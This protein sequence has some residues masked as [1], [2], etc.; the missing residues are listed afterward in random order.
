MNRI[1]E[2]IME[3]PMRWVKDENNPANFQRGDEMM[4]EKTGKS[5]AS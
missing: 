2:Y 3:N 5:P 4:T 1:R